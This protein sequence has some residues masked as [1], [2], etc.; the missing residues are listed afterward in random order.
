MRAAAAGSE[1]S[2]EDMSYGSEVWSRCEA[3]VS[4]LAGELTEQLRLILEPTLASKLAGDYRTG[5]SLHQRCTCFSS[6]AGAFCT[7]LRPWQPRGVSHAHVGSRWRAVAGMALVA[8]Y[9]YLRWLV[10][11]IHGRCSWPSQEPALIRL[12]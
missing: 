5:G 4:G 2:S 12:G 10:L 1:L 3:L 8:V 9:R 6:L 11:V 7:R